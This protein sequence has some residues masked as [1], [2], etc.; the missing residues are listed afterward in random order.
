MPYKLAVIGTGIFATDTH[1]PV[2]KRNTDIDVY[3]CFNR[4]KAKAEKFAETSGAQ[5][6]YDSLDEVFED[7]SVDIVDALLP[8]QTN[9]EVV[10]R[11]IAAK[12]PL[13]IEKPIA[14]N[15]DQ[16]REIV[17]ITKESDV[18]VLVLENWCFRNAIPKLTELVKDIDPVGFT[19]R[20]TGPFVPTSKYMATGW[21]QKPEHIGGYL[22]DGGVHQ[23][24]LLTDVLG[25]V[26]SVSGL[27]KQL[28]DLSGDKDILFSTFTMDS[29]VIGTFTYG[30]AFGATEKKLQFE[31]YGTKGSIVY[32]FSPS[33][34]QSKI[35]VRKGE[36]ANNMAEPEVF[37]FEEGDTIEAEF[38]NFIDA[39]KSN[40]KSKLKCTPERAFHHFA[41]IVACVQSEGKLVDV[42]RP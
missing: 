42:E 3:S 24:A 6:V 23:L 18:P 15:L 21:R 16:A 4:T 19:Y 28:R 35:T 36:D 31:I 2:L 1:L 39:V 12:K 38:A 25:P 27:T 32:D 13:S 7:S 26:K 11:A 33:L 9:L 10:K 34:K 41:V 17:K 20:S 22:S 8:V 29:G 30:S 40:D 37:D 14:A 5:K